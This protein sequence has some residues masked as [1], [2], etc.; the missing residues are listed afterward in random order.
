MQDKVQHKGFSRVTEVTIFT[1]VRGSTCTCAILMHI[2]EES[3]LDL[4]AATPA[5][6]AEIN[7]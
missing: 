2:E 7:N 4:Q 6:R 5:R 1:E 3:T